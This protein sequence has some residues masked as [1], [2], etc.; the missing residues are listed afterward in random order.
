MQ[1]LKNVFY[2]GLKTMLPIL[3]TVAVVIWV[4][5]AVEV[6]FGFLLKLIIPA[7]YYVPGMGALFGLVLIFLVGFVM[8]AIMISKLYEYFEEQIKKIPLIKVVYQSIQDVMAFMSQNKDANTGTAVLVEV[9]GLGKVIGFVTREQLGECKLGNG[10]DICVYMPMS[11]QIGGYTLIM[12]RNRVTRIEMSAQ[13]AMSFAITAGI[14]ST[15]GNG[16]GT[17]RK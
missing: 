15:S 17:T 2:R 5:Q 6:F 12:P 16:N 1:T 13:E 10:D 4:M 3:I 9:P 8:N 14:K 11:Y 7:S